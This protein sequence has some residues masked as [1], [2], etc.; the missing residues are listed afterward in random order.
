MA[1][2]TTNITW[3]D[4]AYGSGESSRG[5]R[6][7][8]YVNKTSTN[9][10]TTLTV[11]VWF[12]SKYG[13]S[14]N[15]GNALYLDNL[16]SAGSATTDRGGTNIQTTVS[17]GAGWSTSNQVK[18][19]S[20]S[21]TWKH[22]RG[23]SATTRYLYAK[24]TGVDRVGATMY[25]SKT[26]SIPALASYTI[27]YNANGGSGAPSSQTKYYGKN[28]TL[29]S[30]TPTRTGYSFQGWALTKANADAGTAYYDAGGTCGK[31]ENLTLYAVWKANT[32]AVTYNAN[33]TDV[34]NLPSQQTKTYGITLKLS[35]TIPKRTNYNFL[36][37]A[38]SASATTATYAAGANYTANS[39]VMLYA[40]WELAYTKPR[41]TNLS[42]T[43]CD[44]DGNITDKGTRV[45]INFNWETDYADPTI[46][47][48]WSPATSD[49]CLVEW[50][51]NSGMT[52]E[53][54]EEILE[55]DDVFSTD[56]TYT[57]T[58]TVEDEVGYSAEVVTLPGTKF[59]MDILYEGKGIAFNK[60]AEL[61]GVMD[62]G[63]QTRLLGGLS[64][65]L[66][67]ADTDLDDC[68]TPGFY[69]GENVSAYNYVNCPLTSGTFTL[70]ILSMG[71][72]G[73]I[74]QRLTQCHISTPVVYERMYYK[75]AGWGKWFGGWAYPTLTSQFTMYGTSESANKPRYRKDGRLVEVRGIVTP[76]SDIAGSN[77]I[78]PIFTLPEGY[79]PNSLIYA[80]CQG[81]GTCSWLLR[82]TD[83]GE[84][85]FSR[86]RDGTGY[87]TA[88]ANS[89]NTGT[90]LPFQITYLV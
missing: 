11:E 58:I 4:I 3:G 27:S 17:S 21:Y 62:I 76:T 10:E 37:W 51:Y 55:V 71:D 2:P 28:L 49:V 82:I 78:L 52:S 34:T 67:P 79:R 6:I 84:V 15:L 29:S 59:I 81:S 40:V 83:D 68:H 56:T 12:W 42:I 75:S 64:Y 63:F 89:D 25:A 74:M 30:T 50:S 35:S 44:A 45:K 5:G 24:L 85:G 8:I 14:D 20:K 46:S 60:P 22:T 9:T 70:E 61:E 48:A 72:N 13:V 38:T 57:F 69:M 87:T 19:T 54:V 33:A 80:L 90:W 43:R 16:S 65:V 23:T 53:S 41:I 18:L 39:K 26:V 32:Y 73:Q 66:L 88:K 7:G 86:Y 77:D 36:G 31:N 47:I 1:A